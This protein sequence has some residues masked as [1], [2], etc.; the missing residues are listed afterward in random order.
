MDLTS[1]R[2][3]AWSSM[4]DLRNSVSL[5]FIARVS[6]RGR[7]ADAAVVAPHTCTLSFPRHLRRS[8]LFCF[9]VSSFFLLPSP[10]QPQPRAPQKEVSVTNTPSPFL[11]V[12]T[13]AIHAAYY[14]SPSSTTW[15]PSSCSSPPWF[16]STG[17]MDV[18]IEKWEEL[19]GF[20]AC[21]L[22]VFLRFLHFGRSG[23]RV[24]DFFCCCS[25]D[26]S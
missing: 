16:Y 12:G 6:Q 5:G 14:D 9:S 4:S 1:T 25:L 23:G 10:F 11:L 24:S 21:L 15:P 26:R 7:R 17:L 18:A 8:S 3:K 20:C 2:R 13:R 22:L 19:T